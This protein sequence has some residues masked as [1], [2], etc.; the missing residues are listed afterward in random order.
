[1]RHQLDDL[2]THLRQRLDL[3]L[4]VAGHLHQHQAILTERDRPTDAALVQD[5]VTEHHLLQLGAGAQR[6]GTAAAQEFG[7]GTAREPRACTILSRSVSP[8]SSILAIVFLAD[9][10]TALGAVLAILRIE[11][12]THRFERLRLAGLDLFELDQVIAEL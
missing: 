6:L 3:G 8:S 2:V 10:R 11:L 7:N 12:G 1:M 9:R 5:R 4:L